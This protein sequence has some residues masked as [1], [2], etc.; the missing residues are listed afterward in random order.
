M[1]GD[2]Y[3]RGFARYVLVHL[4]M[5]TG[6]AQEIPLQSWR[7]HNSYNSIRGIAVGTEKIFAASANGIVVVDPADQSISTITKLDGLSS[8]DITSIAYD[9][10]RNQ[11]LVS[12]ADGTL[13]IV[14]AGQIIEYDE[15]RK[16]TTI[17]GS[18]QINQILVN[19][20]VAYLA[21]DYGMVVFDLVQ[22]QVKETWRDLGAGGETLKIFES[23]FLG[24]SIFLASEK[25]VLIGNINDNLLDFARWKRFNQG[26]FAGAVRS[27]T[28]FNS[29][30]YSAINDEG[31]FVYDGGL[32][33]LANFFG[34]VFNK[35]SSGT[36]LY[37]TENSKLWKRDV[38]GTYTQISSV[39]VEKPQIAMEG[40][41]NTVWVGDGRNGLV[42]DQSGSFESYISNG[43]TF[44]GSFRLVRNPNKFIYAVSGGYNSAFQPAGKKELINYF[45]DGLWTIE[46]D[47]LENDVTDV[48][49]AANKTFVASFGSG[50][51]VRENGS[52]VT[53]TTTNSTL[54]NNQISAI[55]YASGNL[56]VANYA[57]SLPLHVLSSDNSWQSFSFPFAASQFPTK[58]VVDLLG[59]VW[60]VANPSQG[61]GIVVY[62]ME[63]NLSVYLT[64]VSGSGGLPSRSVYSIAIDRNGQV[65]IGTSSG[66]AYYPNP[67]AVFSGNINASRP[68]FNGRFLL[69]D[70]T[71]T[72]IEVDGG[73]RKWIGTQ[74]GLWL[75]DA[76]GEKEIYNFRTQNGPLP[77]N[78]IVD[79][80]VQPVTGELF[81][82]TDK[83]IVSYRAEATESTIA[84][85]TVKIFPNPVTAQF[86][87]AVSISGLATD[88]LVKVTDISGRLIWETTA[89]G[90]TATWHVRDASGNRAATGMYLVIA[91]AQDASESIVGKIAVIN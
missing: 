89:N 45:S 13:D 69:Q 16:S 66:V 59:Q 32:W 87:G 5:V 14:Q 43:P 15:L 35:L 3:F 49:F 17:P 76:F 88:A 83:G 40:N 86:T 90:G 6:Y 7:T 23:T 47:L 44:S 63:K 73:N 46:D 11:L 42:S 24:D 60:M 34:S 38:S 68:I 2:S 79:L 85:G 33:S 27:I 81:V 78:V 8:I 84:F 54:V 41:N 29:A 77:S 70:E 64:N 52:S 21:T 31:L 67:A 10:P 56:F 19:G 61:G 30:I 72:A 1:S 82:G 74:R 26:S 75:F 48:A 4:L 39:K 18:K 20:N 65:W 62:N 22:L 25:G 28:S 58:L 53:Y 55:S 80:E 57:S 50:L 91:I 71:I 36:N 9:T 12:Y 37:I 51:Q